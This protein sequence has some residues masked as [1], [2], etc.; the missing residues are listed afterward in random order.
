VELAYNYAAKTRKGAPVSGVI[1][2]ANADD[3]Y[4]QVNAVLKL[5]PTEI[6]LNCAQ[7]LLAAFNPKPPARDLI[8]LYRT[9][10]E[11]KRI[12]RSIPQGLQDAMEYVDNQ[13]FVSALALMRQSMYDGTRFS[14]AMEKAGFPAT[15]VQAVRSVQVAG[16]EGEILLGLADRMQV[17]EEIKGKIASI[18]WYP[19]T[20][21]ITVWVVAWWMV[22]YIAPKVGEFFQKVSILDI[23]LPGWA[24]AY[25]DFAAFFSAHALVG[26]LLW[27]AIPVG[28]FFCARSGWLSRVLDRVPAFHQLSMKADLI[29]VWSSIGL[30]FS[31]GVKPVELFSSIAAAARR[32]DNADRLREMA[33]IYRS[34]NHSIAKAVAQCNFPRYVQAEIT[35]AE[36][37]NNLTEGIRNLVELMRQDLA[38]HIEQ[39]Q[40]IAM[41]LS[42]GVIAV[43]LIGF[44]FITLYPQISATMSRL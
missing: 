26:T 10:A 25:Y 27:F 28:V 22:L 37:A 19:I 20:V 1:F 30:L 6:K 24:R 34:G 38:H 11:R 17:S 14:E 35:A 8:R 5:D 21:A 31:A 3:A 36:S 42:Y 44:F 41:L 23:A 40:R 29:S 2:S 9:L 16:K 4:Y 33:C 39:T 18:I 15:D 7:S 13:K 43:F 32:E 12:G